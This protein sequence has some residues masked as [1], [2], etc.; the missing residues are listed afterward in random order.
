MT[1]DG[2]HKVSAYH[3]LLHFLSHFSTDQ[4]EIWC[5]VEATEVEHPDT[6]L[7]RFN[8]TK[9]ITTVL[10]TSSTRVNVGMNLDVYESICFKLGVMINAIKLYTWNLI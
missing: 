3:N 10:L 8:E 5:G 9:E 1:L 7:V 4:D 2:G 6:I